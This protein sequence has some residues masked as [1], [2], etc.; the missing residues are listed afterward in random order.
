MQYAK[1]HIFIY[2]YFPKQ[3]YKG[4]KK[5]IFRS[6]KIILS[7]LVQKKSLYFLGFI[8][9]SLVKKEEKYYVDV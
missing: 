9:Y 4:K 3:R 2:L 5:K 7:N 1:I 8:H 6:N